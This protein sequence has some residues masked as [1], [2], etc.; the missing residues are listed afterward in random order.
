M[1]DEL[2]VE[3]LRQ[4]FDFGIVEAEAGKS[5][6]AAAGGDAAVSDR[7]VACLVAGVGELAE[8]P[9]RRGGIESRDDDLDAVLCGK[10]HHLVVVCPV[11]FAGRYF[12]CRP[13]EPMAEGVHAE[14]RSGLVI[15]RP[16]LHRRIGLA[17]VDAARREH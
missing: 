10:I 17:K 5:A 13:H 9:F 4:R 8:G 11:P 7:I 3:V 6:H 15:A 16:I 2:G 1:L 14:L 12:E